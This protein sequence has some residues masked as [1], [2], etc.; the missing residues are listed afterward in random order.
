M[1][2]KILSDSDRGIYRPLP[3]KNACPKAHYGDID[4]YQKPTCESRPAG[5]D[6]PGEREVGVRQGRIE[7]Q[8]NGGLAA[9]V[10]VAVPDSRGKDNKRAGRTFILPTFNFDTHRAAQDVEDLINIVDMHARG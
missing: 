2:P 6:R 8:V 9:A 10:P 3:K 5:L 1:A 7:G 4:R